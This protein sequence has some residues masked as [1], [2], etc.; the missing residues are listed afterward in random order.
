MDDIVITIPA[1]EPTACLPVLIRQL[2]ERFTRLVV[3]DDGSCHSAALFDSIRRIDGVTLL[4]HAVNRGKGAALKT[5]FSEILRRFPN[6]RG[7]VTVD[8]DG[9]HLSADIFRVAKA[10]EDNPDRLTL[11]VRAFDRNVPFRSRLGNWWTRGEFALFTGRDVGDT[12]TGLRGI[13]ITLLPRLLELPG[14]R[15]EYEIAMLIDCVRRLGPPVRVSVTTVYTDGNAS[16]HYRPFRD[17]IRTQRAL[18]ASVFV[19]N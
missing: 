16:S 1:Y 4:T 10:L 2:R 12:Q 6:A 3:V 5:A 7:T 19:R 17:T 9:Q 8:A 14:E 15:Y 13:P 18:F 11:G